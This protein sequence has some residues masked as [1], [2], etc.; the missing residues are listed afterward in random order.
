MFDSP[1]R[2]VG[3]ILRNTTCVMF[4]TYIN[5]ENDVKLKPADD[6]AELKWFTVDDIM[7][8]IDMFHDHRDIISE[9]IGRHPKYAAHNPKY[10]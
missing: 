1:L 2:N 9:M 8:N 5:F 10:L 7:N 4:E 3:G 6:A